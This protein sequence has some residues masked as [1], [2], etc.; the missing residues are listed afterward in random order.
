M[1]FFTK[2]IVYIDS[3]AQKKQI[4]KNNIIIRMEN[5]LFNTK[6]IENHLPKAKDKESYI[7]TSL[8]KCKANNNLLEINELLSRLKSNGKNINIKIVTCFHGNCVFKLLANNKISG[9]EVCSSIEQAFKDGIDSKTVVISTNDTDIQ[10]ATQN[11]VA[12]ISS[13]DDKDSILESIGI[14]QV[15]KR[16]RKAV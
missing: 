11:N 2:P 6:T 5:T 3:S 1:Q 4:M 10:Y 15:K 14:K 8:P 9:V 13:I 12:S 16:N 7:N